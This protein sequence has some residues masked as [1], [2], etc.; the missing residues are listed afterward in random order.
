[1]IMTDATSL[2]PPSAWAGL[3]SNVNNM[4][5]IIPE[6]QNIVFVCFSGRCTKT[7]TVR[8]DSLFPY[9]YTNNVNWSYIMRFLFNT[10]D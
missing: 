8:I 10:N 4:Q 7:M 5:V 1:M 9:W 3:D 2:T 6:D